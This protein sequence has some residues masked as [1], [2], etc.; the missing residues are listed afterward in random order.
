MAGSDWKL[1]VQGQSAEANQEPQFSTW[2]DV[3]NKKGGKSSS[4]G[5]SRR[6]TAAAAAPSEAQAGSRASQRRVVDEALY[7]SAGSSRL[8]VMQPHSGKGPNAMHFIPSHVCCAAD[9]ADYTDMVMAT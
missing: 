2:D 3:L 8:E 7:R 5:S 6:D 9:H 1:G 4:N